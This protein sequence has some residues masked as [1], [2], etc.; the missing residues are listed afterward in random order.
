MNNQRKVIYEQRIEFMSAEDVSQNVKDMRDDV[1]ERIV[2]AFIPPKSYPEQWD[3]EAM[4]KEVFRIYGIHVDAQKWAKEEGV[5]DKEILEK[6]D[7]EIDAHFAAKENAYTA[8]TMRTVEKRILL[9]TLDQLWKEH[10]LG[11]DHLKQGIGLRAYGQK[12]PLNEYK[13]EAFVMFEDMLIKLNEA[14]AGRLSHIELSVQQ[15]EP[16]VLAKVPERKQKM[17]ESRFDPALQKEATVAVLGSS[18]GKV[19]PE[20]RDPQDP[21][22]WGKVARNEVCPC[23]T[24]KKYKQCHGVIG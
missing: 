5:A 3:M 10:L 17:Q 16:E 9:L 14:V 24:G 23:G 2:A 19:D 15:R 21:E 8:Q 20:E 11:L 12:D 7:A 22:T 4:E 18:R 6:L 13:R 1:T